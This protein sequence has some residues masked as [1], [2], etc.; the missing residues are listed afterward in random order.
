KIII[1][2]ELLAPKDAFLNLSIEQNWI[3]VG[4]APC[5]ENYNLVFFL[6]DNKGKVMLEKVY[7]PDPI[8]SKWL[9]DKN[10]ELV[11]ILN[12]PQ[13]LPDGKYSL[14]IAIRDSTDPSLQ[15]ELGI[16]GRD[17]EGR[18]TLSILKLETLP[19]N[20][21]RVLKVIKPK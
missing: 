18:Y 8:V 11:S 1:N 20:Y 7:K 15:I 4:I 17:Q 16:D 3:N 14:K 21:S 19:N 9:P 2:K 12:I 5:Y 6:I 10:I 13:Y